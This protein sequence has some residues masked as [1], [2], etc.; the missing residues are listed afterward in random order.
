MLLTL[1]LISLSWA[2]NSD[3]KP[4]YLSGLPLLSPYQNSIM[5]GKYNV[6]Y[7]FHYEDDILNDPYKKDR[8]E[9][10]LNESLRYSLNK[11]SNLGIAPVDCKEDLNVHLVQLDGQTLNNDDRFGSWRKVNGGNLITIHGLYD[12]TIDTYR[13]SII[14]YMLLPQNSDRVIFHEMAHY[15]YDRFCIYEKNS[16]KTEAFAKAV[17]N[18]YTIGLLD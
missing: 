3:W 18:D 14:I 16:L 1:L 12:P 4:R 17:E 15:W 6:R 5:V 13:D 2:S 7:N 8:I 10:L 11:M 9:F